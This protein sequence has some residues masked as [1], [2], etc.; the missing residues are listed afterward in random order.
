[1]LALCLGQPSARFS[2]LM[3]TSQRRSSAGTMGR[4]W[5]RCHG[6]KFS[7][8]CGSDWPCP[9]AQ[10]HVAA[11]AH[12]PGLRPSVFQ[13]CVG[14]VNERRYELSLFLWYEQGPGWMGSVLQ[15]TE[16]PRAYHLKGFVTP[17]ECD[18]LIDKVHT[19]DTS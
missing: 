8:L 12:V 14:S 5:Q 10:A 7:R 6:C 16:R 9:P 18:W 13:S 3:S 1:M 15:L 17:E 11:T 4:R 19:P 2:M